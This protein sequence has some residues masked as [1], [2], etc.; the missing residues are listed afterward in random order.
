M[1][2][3]STVHH[4]TVYVP[5]PA[6]RLSLT[7]VSVATSVV[8]FLVE[9]PP[10]LQGGHRTGELSRQREVVILSL[11]PPQIWPTSLE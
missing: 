2:G 1:S 10:V 7:A 3:P 4:M 9:V 5:Y 11:P 6:P 8:V